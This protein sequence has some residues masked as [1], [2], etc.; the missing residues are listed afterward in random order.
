MTGT[1]VKPLPVTYVFPLWTRYATLRGVAPRTRG[2]SGCGPIVMLKF[3]S[4][5]MTLVAPPHYGL[6]LTEEDGAKSR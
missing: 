2:V 5:V 1:S 3:R 6:P 4:D